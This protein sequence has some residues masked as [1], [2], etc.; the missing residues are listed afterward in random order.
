MGAPVVLD[1]R[2]LGSNGPLIST[3]G[4]GAF[5]IGR[6]E[7]IKYEHSYDLP[8]DEQVASL[9]HGLLQA[10]VNYF[11]TAPAYGLSE[12]RLGE[13]LPASDQIIVSTKVG[14]TFQ[15]GRSTHDFSAGGIDQSIDR[16]LR[17]LRRPRLDIV[18][19]HSDGNDLSILESSDAIP[20][21]RRRQE[22]GDIGVMGFSGKTLQGHE[23]AL[24]LDVF[25]ALMVEYNLGNREQEPIL[26]KAQARGVGVVIKK[27]LGSGT[28]DPHEAIPFLAKE[29]ITSIVVGGLDLDHL[30]DDVRLAT[31]V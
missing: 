18:F 7:G 19:I 11:D 12:K 31:Q 17:L 21:L 26:A 20:A 25:G 2:Q 27:G 15:D 28:L 29:P 6:N 1:R 24:S 8:T 13:H 4:F 9:I 22:A 10:G 30:L 23:H 16:S 5:K 14:E 3:I